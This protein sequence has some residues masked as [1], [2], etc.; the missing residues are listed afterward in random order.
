M[1]PPDW[2]AYATAILE[3]EGYD[4][5]LYDFPAEGWDKRDLRKLIKEEQP[6]VVVVDSTTPS[7]YSDI[8]SAGIIKQNS[9]ARVIM[10]GT[11]ATAFPEEVLKSGFIDIVARGEYDYVVRDAINSIDNLDRIRGISYIRNGKI[12]HNEPG[13]LIQD[14]DTLPFPAWHYL[15]IKHYFDAVKLYPFI[16][17]I[18]SRGCPYRCIFCLWPQVMHG[19]QL[20]LRSARNIVDEIQYDLDRCLN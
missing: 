7:I 19:R 18:G 15:N 8:D 17:I 14:L 10:V 16:D 4:V 1:R 9:K 11:H 12:L 13:E 6:D 20:R 3:K 5:K 2:L